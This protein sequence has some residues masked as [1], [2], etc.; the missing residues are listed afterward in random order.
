MSNMHT[1]DVAGSVSVI[2]RQAFESHVAKSHGLERPHL[3]VIFEVIGTEH[4]VMLEIQDG[5]GHTGRLHGV[6]TTRNGYD[7][8]TLGLTSLYE[9]AHP[10]YYRGPDIRQV[11]VLDDCT[12]QHRVIS[13]WMDLKRDALSAVRATL[14]KDDAGAGKWDLTPTGNGEVAVRRYRRLDQWREAP[15]R[16]NVLRDGTVR[17]HNHSPLAPNDYFKKD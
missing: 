13:R 11:V 3:E 4:L 9:G 1:V 6:S 12:L 15:D 16:W 17:L 7:T 2:R 10:T 14:E 8:P 5:F